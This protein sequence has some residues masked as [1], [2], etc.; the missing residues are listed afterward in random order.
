MP[1]VAPLPLTPRRVVAAIEALVGEALDLALQ[2]LERAA[3]S[4]SARLPGNCRLCRQRPGGALGEYRWQAGRIFT[5]FTSSPDVRAPAND[6]RWWLAERLAGWDF[7]RERSRDRRQ[8]RLAR[9]GAAAKPATKPADVLAPPQD[10]QAAHLAFGRRTAPG[11]RL[12]LVFSGLDS[13]SNTAPAPACTAPRQQERRCHARLSLSEAQPDPRCVDQDGSPAP[14]GRCSSLAGPLANYAEL[15]RV[16]RIPA[17]KARDRR[18]FDLGPAPTLPGSRPA[19]ADAN[20]VRDE[21]LPG[22]YTVV[23]VDHGS[24][25]VVVTCRPIRGANARDRRIPVDIWAL[26]SFTALRGAIQAASGG[27]VVIVQPDEDAALEIAGWPDRLTAP[28][29]TGTCN[30]PFKNANGLTTAPAALSNAV[31]SKCHRDVQAADRARRAELLSHTSV[32]REGPDAVVTP[33]A[34]KAAEAPRR[35]ALFDNDPMAYL[36]P[37]ETPAGQAAARSP[38]RLQLLAA[39]AAGRQALRDQGIDPES[40]PAR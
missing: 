13:S 36:A 25:Q 40:V 24:A 2:R 28:K 26:N 22:S 9:P 29:P 19:D 39:S 33:L 10:H 11:R 23:R 21:R 18:E 37:L 8:V 17:L 14:C 30:G 4:C 15:P 7:D 6:P 1:A 35:A 5:S 32:G 16:L 27:D 3:A 38:R 20:G 31:L 12:A 34:D